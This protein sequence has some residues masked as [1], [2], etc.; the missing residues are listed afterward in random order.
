MLVHFLIFHNF[1]AKNNNQYG[2]TLKTGKAVEFTMDIY[3]TSRYEKSQ[4]RKGIPVCSWGEAGIGKTELPNFLVRE[5][6]DFFDGN[7]VYLPMAQIEEKAELQGLPELQTTKRL[8][9]TFN[10]KLTKALAKDKKKKVKIVTG[11]IGTKSV[12]YVMSTDEVSSDELTDFMSPK[13]MFR[14]PGNDYVMNAKNEDGKVDLYYCMPESLDGSQTIIEE[15]INGKLKKYILDARTIYATPSWIPQVSTHGEKGLLVIDDMNRA[16][17][18]IINSIMQLLQDGALLGWKLPEQWEIYCTCNP[19]DG[20]Y[21]VTGFDGAQMTRMANYTQRFDEKSWL[22]AWAIPTGIHA[23]AQNFVMT[24][25]EAIVK[26]ERTNPRSFD[27]FFR[28]IRSTLDKVKISGDRMQ[29]GGQNEGGKLAKKINDYGLMNIEEESLQV[30]ISFLTSG[31]GKLPSIEEILDPKFDLKKFYGQI[32]DGG[33]L[34]VDILTALNTRLVL[35]LKTEGE[36]ISD[37]KNVLTGVKRWMK[38]E[39]LPADLRLSILDDVLMALPK[40]VDQEL[41][42]LIYSRVVRR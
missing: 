31:Y 5:Y 35:F 8:L 15:T 16:D 40:V 3:S 36:A 38:A 6:L 21:D 41:T 4:G 1:M 32:T 25:P 34:R 13:E 27:K 2:P 26:G 9:K 11:N 22:E 7:I 30:F 10:Y 18:R 12:D 14:L 28:M 42:Q 29:L 37:D 24:Y 23:V 20:K 19:D 39:K 17:G 33:S